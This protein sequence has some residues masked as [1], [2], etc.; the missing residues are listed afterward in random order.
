M[1]MS[2]QVL[3]RLIAGQSLALEF[4]SRTDAHTFRTA[5]NVTL[6]RK[7]HEYELLGLL[8]KGMN[9]T[10]SIAPTD[11]GVV[12]SLRLIKKQTKHRGPTAIYILEDD[13]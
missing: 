1:S 7:R 4:L 5:V 2:M 12:L 3:N 6:T 9:L 13:S 10:T 11:N 8:E